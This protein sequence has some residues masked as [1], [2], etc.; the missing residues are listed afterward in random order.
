MCQNYKCVNRTVRVHSK[1]SA[2]KVLTW[3]FVAVCSRRTGSS[4]EGF[5][6]VSETGDQSR[7]RWLVLM[8][9]R[10]RRPGNQQRRRVNNWKTLHVSTAI[11]NWVWLGIHNQWRLRS[12]SLM[13]SIEM[14][15]RIQNWLEPRMYARRQPGW[16]CY[17]HQQRQPRQGTKCNSPPTKGQFTSH[18]ILF[19]TTSTNNK[20]DND[21]DSSCAGHQL[22]KWQSRIWL[23]WLSYQQQQCI[24]LKRSQMILTANLLCQLTQREKG[25]PTNGQS[26]LT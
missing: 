20:W 5:T 23:K 26:N 10:A 2:A 24:V 21:S 12:A 9:G 14:S 25:T 19:V 1:A 4:W 16:R 15:S 3:H 7:T 18:N 6:A 22:G 11:L 8:G 17:Q 13:C